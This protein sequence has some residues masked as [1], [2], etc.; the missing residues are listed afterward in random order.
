[1]T[2]FISSVA[3]IFFLWLTGVRPIFI[4]L[5]F[6]MLYI[7][8]VIWCIWDYICRKNFYDSM[9][10]ALREMDQKSLFMEVM[11]KPGFKEGELFYMILSEEGRYMN[12]IIAKEKRETK[13]YREY[14]ESWVHEIKTPLTLAGLICDKK[15]ELEEK[16]IRT[17]LKRMESLIDQAL[18]YAR[19][20]SV[21]K[22]FIM[23]KVTLK[24]LVEDTLK[25]NAS[26]LIEEKVVPAMNNLDQV[27]YADSK[28]IVFILTQLITNSVKY[29]KKEEQLKLSFEGISFSE[30]ICLNVCDNGIGIVK[31]DLSRVFDKGFTGSN[32]RNNVKSTGIG[33]YLCQRLCRQMNLRI[34]I[35][36]TEGEGTMVSIYFPKGSMT[37]VAET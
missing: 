27:V 33:L 36:S 13:E 28:W 6:M 10:E 20:T 8:V 35:Q 17:Q 22:D 29:R 2:V 7:P 11:E 12:N 14:V 16:E 34:E 5:L 37:S 1:M 9:L 26:L 30:G 19:S 32:G 23:R 3:G 4:A 31:E 18:F 15:Q 25:K 24:E 21:E